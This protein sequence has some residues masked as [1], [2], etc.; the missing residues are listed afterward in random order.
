M[1]VLQTR[2]L[3][4]LA[5]GLAVG[6]AGC[7]SGGGSGGSRGGGPNRLTASDLE[8]V[9]QLDAYQAIQ[10]LRPR[11]LR[12][13]GGNYAAVFVD[14]TERP[15]GL[16][17]LRSIRVAEVEEMRYMSS[18]DATTRYGTGYDGGVILITTKR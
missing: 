15:G 14:G 5:F 18:T 6:L 17:V 9:Q 16:D 13:R 7:A 12:T 4:V 11:W 1:R 10:R 2:N 3:L 8:P